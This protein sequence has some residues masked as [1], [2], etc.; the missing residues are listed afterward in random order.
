MTHQIGRP[1]VQGAVVLGLLGQVLQPGHE[2][3]PSDP[4][5]CHPLVLGDQGHGVSSQGRGEGAVELVVVVGRG[6]RSTSW[7][8]WW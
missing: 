3:L 2:A 5:P 8:W 1:A 6:G 7:W 4:V